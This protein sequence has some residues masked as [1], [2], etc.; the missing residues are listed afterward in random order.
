MLAAR[1]SACS[2]GVQRSRG[3]PTPGCLARAPFACSVPAPFA[4]PVSVPA[5]APP[6]PRCT[7]FN[8]FLQGEENEGEEEAEANAPKEAAPEVG[9]RKSS[10]S[11]QV[12]F[13]VREEERRRQAE[14]QQDLLERVNAATLAAFNVGGNGSASGAGQ[15]RKVSAITAYQSPREFASNG[16]MTV[17]V[18]HKAESVLVPIYGHLVP[19]HVLTIKNATVNQARFGGERRAAER[20]TSGE[21]L[22]GEAVRVG[23]CRA[24]R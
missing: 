15:G 21:A 17:Q 23:K 12:D 9:F 10:R 18:D 4:A 1:P 2:L 8:P 3:A 20:G 6:T 5:P 24:P 7:R 14:T 16:L 22:L 13:K 19:F 11:E